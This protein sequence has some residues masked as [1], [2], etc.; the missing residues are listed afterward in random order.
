MQGGWIKLHRKIM[1]NWIYDFKNPALFM[2]WLDLLLMANHEPRKINIKGQIVT[3][4]TGQLWTSIR[5]LSDRWRV[6]K[7]T[8]LRRLKM[9]QS[10]GMIYVDSHP[11]MGTLVTVCNYGI[12]QGFSG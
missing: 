9:L 5:K 6:K 10:D 8:T 4:G 7:D 2:D 3:V 12:Y 11:G 1:D